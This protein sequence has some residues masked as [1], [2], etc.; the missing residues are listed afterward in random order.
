MKKNLVFII[1][2]AWSCSTAGKKDNT[3]TQQEAMTLDAATFKQKLDAAPEAILLDVRTPGEVAEG[4]IPGATVIDFSAPDFGDKIS[5][6]DKEKP[7]FIY[8]KS[9]G[10]SSKTVAKMKEEGFK[11]LYSLEGG[12]NAWVTSGF[13]TTIP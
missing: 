13:E 5:A 2:A 11:K 7:Y 10:R 3:A 4:V 9:G 1:L 6:L 12:Y 8:C